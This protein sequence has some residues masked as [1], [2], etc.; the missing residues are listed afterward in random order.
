M[1]Y[2]FGGM[3]ESSD[4]FTWTEV[5]YFADKSCA[6]MGF[7]GNH[8][9]VLEVSNLHGIYWSDDS[10]GTAGMNQLGVFP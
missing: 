2:Q 8:L 3:F 1:G 7:Y 9:V 10:G 4:G 6:A 5:P